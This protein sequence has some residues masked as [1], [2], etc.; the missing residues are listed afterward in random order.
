MPV[1]GDVA[2]HQGHVTVL[3]PS[4]D[5][6]QLSR[7]AAHLS[8]SLP[9]STHLSCSTV[10]TSLM[11]ATASSD[12]TLHDSHCAF[13]P[14]YLQ[15]VSFKNLCW[16]FF[17]KFECFHF[18]FASMKIT[19]TENTDVSDVYWCIF[20]L[21]ETIDYIVWSNNNM[22]WGCS[23]IMAWL[24][25]CSLRGP[26]RAHEKTLIYNTMTKQWHQA[27]MKCNIEGKTFLPF[28][29]FLRFLKTQKDGFWIL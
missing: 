19:K 15:S 4:T 17:N 25:T 14:M 11:W 12:A 5:V 1:C 6:H 21:L 18:I 7:K 24:G 27:G 29:Y 2:A 10:V 28:R 16:V 8:R 26:T 9:G 13:S 20:Y 23:V 22:L 3:F